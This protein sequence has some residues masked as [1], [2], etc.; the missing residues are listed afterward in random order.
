MTATTA[1]TKVTAKPTNAS[2]TTATA[3]PKSVPDND[4]QS[5]IA[6]SNHKG[7]IADLKQVARKYGSFVGPGVLV[8]VAYVDPGNY[9]TGV[10]AGASLKYDLL[11]VIFLSNVFAVFL[12]SLSAK[13]GSVTGMDLAQ[14]CREHFPPWLNFILYILSEVAIIATDLAEVIGSAIALNILIKVPL[15]AG[16]AITIIEVLVVLIFY[17]PD[18]AMRGIRAFEFAVALLV[19]GVMVCFCIELSHITN[20]SFGEVMRGYLPSPG[21]VQGQGIYLSAGILG[22]TIMPHSLFLGSGI[23]QPR[24]KAYD[25]A[26]GYFSPPKN[27]SEMSLPYRPSLAAIRYSLNYCIAELVISL[28]TFALFIN[29]AI[30]IVA[31]ATLSGTPEAV[32]AD[33]FS[34]HDLLS[35]NV[36]KAAGLL[37]ALALLFS[38]SSAGVV[39]TLAGQMV[40]EGFLR[41]TIR[42]WI[43]RLVTR[44]IAILP[45][46]VVATAVGRPGLAAVL[47]ASQVALSILL[48]FV[49]APLIYFTTFKKFMRVPVIVEGTTIAST[50]SMAAAGAGAGAGK[51]ETAVVVVG[52]DRQ[53]YA[54]LSNSW[55]TSILAVLIWCFIAMLNVY[56]IV[57]LGIGKG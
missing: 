56:L 3:K 7:W 5:T 11:F 10:A 51:R 29:S 48:P 26:A 41:W 28:V 57:L 53:E 31:G 19:I 33:L 22:A 32:D 46:I 49:T 4:S 21:M 2:A 20:S 1:T 9:S 38:G 6:S 39:C 30:L 15:P 37:F 36:G 52:E 23:V 8:S 16:V 17:R 45:C 44:T 40:S 35:Q 50:A 12:Q 55:P 25:I 27:E 34:I 14:N 42:P 18:G 47:N 24:V 43:R 13:L 54:D